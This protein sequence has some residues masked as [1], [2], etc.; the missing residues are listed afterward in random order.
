MAKNVSKKIS[1]LSDS[2]DKNLYV[3]KILREQ[4]LAGA[5]PPGTKI[6]QNELAQKLGVS[7]TPIINSLH[8]LESDGLVDKVPNV[9]FFVH[10]MNIKELLDVF[11]LWVGLNVAAMSQLREK[12]IREEDIQAAKEAFAAYTS[13][14]P[15]EGIDPFEYK[16]SNFQFHELLLSLGSNQLISKINEQFQVFTRVSLGGLLRSPEETL[17]E[18]LEIIQALE[19]KRLDDLCL[20]LWEHERKGCQVLA[21]LMNKLQSL[22]LQMDKLYVHEMFPLPCP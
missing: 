20:L 7:R 11:A 14:A 5:I 4:I 2:T 12:D 16:K 22:N 1:R 9:G 21:E 18:H 6:K 17:P 10:K 8:K 13:L 3:Y 19:E 15:G